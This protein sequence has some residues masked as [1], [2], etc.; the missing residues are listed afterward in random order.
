M[1]TRLVLLMIL[2]SFFA[3]QAKTEAPI[4]MAGLKIEAPTK[5]V[6]VKAEVKTVTTVP[7]KTPTAFEIATDSIFAAVQ[8]STNDSGY[9]DVNNL[10]IAYKSKPAGMAII[11][12]ARR[13][14]STITNTTLLHIAV[15]GN[16]L[17][18]TAMLFQKA[19]FVGSEFNQYFYKLMGNAVDGM[20]K[21]AIDYTTVG[22]P[23]YNFLLPFS[24]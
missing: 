5:T 19:S 20:N 12:S 8:A 17:G 9:S 18:I 6:D 10:L 21:K 1:K 24:S 14:I 7:L 3:M 15:Q 13:T 23:I 11:L 4:K 22:S 16:N 2:S